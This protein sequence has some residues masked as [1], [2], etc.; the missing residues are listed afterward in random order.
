MFNH[1]QIAAQ[2]EQSGQLIHIGVGRY[3]K[4]PN[5]PDLTISE[6]KAALPCVRLKI[7]KKYYTARPSGRLNAFASVVPE[8]ETTKS[9]HIKDFKSLLYPAV[10]FSWEAVTRAVNN[11]SILEG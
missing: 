1:A 10:E 4:A 6:V 9:G 7:G 11:N 8:H 3:V 5:A 2:A